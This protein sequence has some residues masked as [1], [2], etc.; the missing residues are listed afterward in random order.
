[1]ATEPLQNLTEQS[2]RIGSWLLLV[3]TKPRA[4]DYTWTRGSTTSSGRKIEVLLVSQDSTQYCLGQFTRKGKEPAATKAFN[5]A[6]DRFKKGSVWRVN[7]IS[8]AKK[9]PKYLGCSHKVVIDLN[10]SNFQ[11]VLQSTVTMPEQATPPEDLNTLLQCSPGQLIDVIAFAT[12]VSERR[13]KQ[14]PLGMRDLVDITIMDD[15]GDSNAAKS[16]FPAWF[17]TTTSGEP[18][19]DLK[20][21]YAM[22]A[23]PVPVAFFN[24]VCLE[25]NG[26]PILKT[27]KSSFAF[28]AVRVGPKAERLLAQANTLLAT[29]ASNVTVVTELPVFQPRE[30][31]DYLSAKATLTVA[32]LL[33]LARQDDSV[34]LSGSS[35][36]AAE[37]APD[38]FQINHARI[39][40][41]KPGEYVLTKHGE[42]LW[43]NMRVIDST[44]TIDIRMREKVA[45]LLSGAP[46]AARFSTLA[47]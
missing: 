21:L 2:A 17:P 15:S 31:I 39:L 36:G 44:G 22:V 26:K 43:P 4:Q 9:D 27:S 30:A 40:E 19:D 47:A 24:L 42:R 16:E 34:I 29:D 10:A 11:P 8:L 20:R 41:P 32:R 28:E 14:T 46:D 35:A 13:Q 25:E 1:M 5:E 37:H 33:H 3:A 12:N 38:L 18:C 45:L 6:T 7:K 23:D